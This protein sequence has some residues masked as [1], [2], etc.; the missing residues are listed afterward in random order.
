MM[1]SMLERGPK[2]IHSLIMFNCVESMWL[3]DQTHVPVKGVC[4]KFPLTLGSEGFDKILILLID[5]LRKE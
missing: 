2:F 5:Y 3:K 4:R 1:V